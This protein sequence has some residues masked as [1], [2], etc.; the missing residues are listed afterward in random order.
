L[1]GFKTDILKSDTYAAMLKAAVSSGGHGKNVLNG[2]G[3]AKT[4]T[5]AQSKRFTKR[6]GCSRALPLYRT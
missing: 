1:A 5:R 3:A 2:G 4:I 6:H